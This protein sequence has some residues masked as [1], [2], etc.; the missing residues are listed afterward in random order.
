MDPL[1]HLVQD[2]L[3]QEKQAIIFAPT[4][5]SAEKMAEDLAKGTSI[6]LSELPQQ[7]LQAV[8]TPTTQ[9]RKLSNCVRKG[10]A[11]HHAGLVERQRELIEE[12]FRKGTIKI[13]CSTPTLAAGIS[14]PAFRVII[15][16]L[17]RYAHWGGMDWIPVLEYLQMAGRAGR[18]EYERMGESIVLAKDEAEREEIHERYICGVPEEIYSK[19]SAEPVLRTHLLS[20]IASQVIVDEQS[21]EH[22]FSKT[23]WAFHYGDLPQ[24]LQQ[25]HL[26]KERLREWQFLVS[27]DSHSRDDIS[28]EQ[29]FFVP[30]AMIMNQG[31]RGMVTTTATKTA[32]KITKKTEA[33]LQVTPLG[34]RVAELYLDPLTARQMLNGLS[35][36]MEG[37]TLFSLLHLISFTLELRPLL[38]V[39]KK[40]EGLIEEELTKK[41]P[42]LLQDEPSPFDSSY[43]EFLSSIKTALFFEAWIN[44]KDEDFLFEHFDIR[45][46]EIRSKL[47]RAD[48]LL[49]AGDELAQ[50]QGLRTVSK[51]LKKLRFLVRHGAKE[52]LLP[53][54]RLKGIGRKRARKLFDKGYTTLGALRHASLA[55]LSVVVGPMVAEEVL[56][57]LGE[58]EK[59]G[60]D[61][62]EM[63]TTES[64]AKASDQRKVEEFGDDC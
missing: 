41:A 43:D 18:P 54:L 2:T 42:L 11:F 52:E 24:L 9:C 19:L 32:T 51:E 20:L 64:M 45:P 28:R 57:Q 53:L 21:M 25:L 27:D 8:S 33:K 22:F 63:N 40:E 31:K 58:D 50:L 37:K 5:I 3:A 29:D 62:R 10:V 12:E 16:S 15:K 34:K 44:E 49:Y 1:L 56:R 48:W 13:I 38:S 23:F 35:R 61:R 60:M 47:E 14:T 59:I 39:R 36:F 46:G 7:I 4:R 55:D 26:H 6:F 30:A 17:K